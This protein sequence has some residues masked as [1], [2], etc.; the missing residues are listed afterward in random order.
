MDNQLLTGRS[1]LLV[2]PTDN[3][4]Q[5]F[6]RVGGG[7]KTPPLRQE[8]DDMKPSRPPNNCQHEFRQLNS[9][10]LSIWWC[11]SRSEPDPFMIRVQKKSGLVERQKVLPRTALVLLRDR[12]ELF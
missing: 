2:A 9:V 4:R 3:L 8:L 7:V 11:L 6:S 10:T 5:D 12:Q 1:S